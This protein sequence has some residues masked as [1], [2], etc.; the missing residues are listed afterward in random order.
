MKPQ[1][2]LVWRGEETAVL[3]VGFLRRKNEVKQL[4]F[5]HQPLAWL[6]L[7]CPHLSHVILQAYGAM[8]EWAELT[9]LHI[10]LVLPMP[11]LSWSYN[12]PFRLGSLCGCLWVVEADLQ[13]L[14]L[15]KLKSHLHWWVNS[16]LGRSALLSAEA[17]SYCELLSNVPG[18]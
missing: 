11:F 13:L 2:A 12:W 3:S 10:L 18:T 14:L 17:R 8:F 5:C 4:H 15:L 9:K 16:P 7:L 1:K 6:L